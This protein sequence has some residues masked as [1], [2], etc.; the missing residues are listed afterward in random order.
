M[1]PMGTKLGEPSLTI[2]NI[3]LKETKEELT[4]V[5]KELKDM[6]TELQKASHM[7]LRS[8]G[9]I[10]SLESK[11]QEC[12]LKGG[13]VEENNHKYNSKQGNEVHKEPS[14]SNVSTFTCKFSKSELEEATKFF[15]PSLIIWERD[16]VTIYKGFL[17]HT[18][19]AIKIVKSQDIT[20]FNQ[21]VLLYSRTLCFILRLL[22]E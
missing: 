10:S 15:D 17:Y 13:K 11:M 7:L 6:K 21:E 9:E 12:N 4:R 2:L 16:H 8:P 20:K 3:Q 5:K 22:S 14:S 1:H 19:V 18:E